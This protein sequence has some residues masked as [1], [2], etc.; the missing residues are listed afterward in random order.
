M[1]VQLVTNKKGFLHPECSVV[2]CRV[3]GDQLFAMKSQLYTY[4]TQKYAL[5]YTYE[6][7]GGV[8]CGGVS[9]ARC[10]QAK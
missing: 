5:W 4:I 3:D 8:L 6:R 9:C 7:A 1:L 2:Q 10:Q